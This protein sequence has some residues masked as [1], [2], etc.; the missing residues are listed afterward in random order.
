MFAALMLLVCLFKN[1]YFPIDANVLTTFPPSTN[2]IHNNL[3]FQMAD[4]IHEVRL[5]QMQVQKH[6]QD[7]EAARAR[8]IEQAKREAREYRELILQREV[9]KERKRRQAIAEREAAERE[10]EKY[11]AQMTA[12]ETARRR[13]HREYRDALD[14]QIDLK[15]SSRTG[16][17]HLSPAER[18]LNKRMLAK[19]AT[20]DAGKHNDDTSSQWNGSQYSV[21]YGGNPVVRSTSH[22][23]SPIG[24]SSHVMAAGMRSGPRGLSSGRTGIV[25]RAEI[26]AA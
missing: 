17:S 12:R 18:S 16:T 2:T 21:S 1:F 6:R 7:E 4:E 20:L 13:K 14:A 10:A 15:Y 3:V 24:G 25:T 23:T 19:M 22:Q 26:S 11:R 5:L 9:E 8:A